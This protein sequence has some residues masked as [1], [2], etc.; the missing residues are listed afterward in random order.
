MIVK[1]IL[2]RI[3]EKFNIFKIK[4][5]SN[6]WMWLIDYDFTKKAIIRKKLIKLLKGSKKI[7][8]FYMECHIDIYREQLFE[9]KEFKKK[10]ISI[11]PFGTDVLSHIYGDKI[12]SLNIWKNIDIFIYNPGVPTKNGLISLNNVLDLLNANCKTISVTNAAFKGYMPQHTNNIIGKKELFCWGDKNI[13]ELI[14]NNNPEDDIKKLCDIK[15]Y[16]EEYINKYFE[17]SLK[18]M[19]NFEK[20]CTIKISDYIKKFGKKRLLY[21]SVTHPGIE[22][23]T[24]ISK[25][26]CKELNLDIGGLRQGFKELRIHEEAVYPSVATILGIDVKERKIVPGDDWEPMQFE[27]YIHNYYKTMKELKYIK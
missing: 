10:Y 8:G 1:K 7:V 22:V 6:F 26:L 23:M 11:N 3:N 13:N 20:K 9:S 15:Y 17:K 16:D 5:S 27:E 24:E 25:R 12:N 2:K 21:L 18:Q 19:E 4:I 14:E